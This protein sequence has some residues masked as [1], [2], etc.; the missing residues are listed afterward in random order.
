MI[1]AL[2]LACIPVI[3]LL[4]EQVLIGLA[5]IAACVIGCGVILDAASNSNDVKER[6]E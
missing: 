2:K 3:D 6:G 4:T 5:V 1:L